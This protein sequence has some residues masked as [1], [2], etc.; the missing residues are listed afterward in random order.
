MKNQV[1]YPE[2]DR[3]EITGATFGKKNGLTGKTDQDTFAYRL[4]NL[5]RSNS[6]KGQQGGDRKVELTLVLFVGL[7]DLRFFG[8]VCFL[9]LLVSG[10]GYG[11]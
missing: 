2:S 7:F 1:G 11:L 4:E 10:K 6:G 5:R 3:I 9:L 8:F